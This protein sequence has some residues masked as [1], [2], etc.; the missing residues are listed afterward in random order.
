MASDYY[1]KLEPAGIEGCT[2]AWRPKKNAKIEI[3]NNSGSKQILSNITNDVLLD[4][5]GNPVADITLEDGEDWE[6]RIGQ[7]QG[8]YDYD[9]GDGTIGLR[10]GTIDPS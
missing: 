1:I 2:P 8:T 6:G 5:N 10:S 7:S 4:K 3:T 9:D